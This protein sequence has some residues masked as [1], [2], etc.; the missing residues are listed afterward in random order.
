MHG[1]LNTA[2]YWQQKESANERIRKSCHEKGRLNIQS[3]CALAPSP[4][5]LAEHAG[6]ASW[7]VFSRC[8][9]LLDDLKAPQTIIVKEN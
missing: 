8:R 6:G 3:R 4:H 1:F 9:K 5:F 7:N 2:I